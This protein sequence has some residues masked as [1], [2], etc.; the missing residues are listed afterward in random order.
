MAPFRPSQFCGFQ[1]MKVVAERSPQL[2]VVGREEG[3]DEGSLLLGFW[4]DKG[5]RLRSWCWVFE[6]GF[7]EDGKRCCGLGGLN[8]GVTDWI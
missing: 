4:Q 1:S 5:C 8:A 2:A 7:Y 6:G 3:N